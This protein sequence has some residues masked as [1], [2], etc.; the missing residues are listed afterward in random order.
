[1][2]QSKK[3]PKHQDKDFEEVL[4]IAEDQDWRVTKRPNSYF[5]MCCPCPDEHKKTMHLTPNRG[6]LK[7]L[8]G[9]LTPHTCWRD[10]R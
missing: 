4:C 8:V 2:E 9:Y 1:V 5:I 7:S 6:Y 3:R 10:E